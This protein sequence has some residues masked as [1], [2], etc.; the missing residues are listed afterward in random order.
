MIDDL[1]VKEDGTKNCKLTRFLVPPV[2]YSHVFIRY[3][4]RKPAGLVLKDECGKIN[5]PQDVNGNTIR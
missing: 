4:A 5:I 3:A 2:K 1:E